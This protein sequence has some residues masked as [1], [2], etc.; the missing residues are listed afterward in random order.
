MSTATANIDAIGP[1]EWRGNWL[2][3]KYPWDC[4]SFINVI[5]AVV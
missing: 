3:E 1:I 4:S 2:E 5:I